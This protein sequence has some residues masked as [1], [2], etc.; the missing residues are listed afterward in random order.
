MAEEIHVRDL[1]SRTLTSHGHTD[2]LALFARALADLQ[3]RQGAAPQGALPAQN[4]DLIA[5]LIA[6]DL[7]LRAEADADAGESGGS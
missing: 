3:E 7:E 1:P 4:Q 5:R 2:A 6:R